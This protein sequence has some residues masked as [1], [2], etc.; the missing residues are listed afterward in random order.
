MQVQIGLA[1][2]G[3]V[4][5]WLGLAEEVV[6]LF[7][8]M[9][10]FDAVLI[11]KIA[12]HRA[13]CARTDDGNGRFV[14][15]VLIGGGGDGY[16]IRWLAV[17]SAFQRLGVGRSLVEAA[18]ANIPAKASIH[19]DTFVAGSPGAGPARGLYESCGFV[20][21]DVWTQGELVRQRYVRLP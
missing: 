18:I 5:P 19:V 2:H 4:E 20:P 8:P 6:P 11:R 13:Y 12:Q 15:G 10:D 9:P 7:G 14:G 21:R 17:R 1:R 3:D 16:S